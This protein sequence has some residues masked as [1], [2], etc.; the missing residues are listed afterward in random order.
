M[1]LCPIEVKRIEKSLTRLEL[2]LVLDGSEK[3]TFPHTSL[4][5][6]SPLPSQLAP[7]PQKPFS[8]LESSAAVA[9]ACRVKSKQEKLSTKPEKDIFP[10]KQLPSTRLSDA[11]LSPV[12]PFTAMTTSVSAVN[13]SEPFTERA[14]SVPKLNS[15]SAFYVLNSSASVIRQKVSLANIVGSDGSFS[16]F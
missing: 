7:P 10:E 2:S 12:P 11:R 14:E 15:N 1:L 16:L 9:T 3:M 6:S 8:V 5:V 4:C 13:K